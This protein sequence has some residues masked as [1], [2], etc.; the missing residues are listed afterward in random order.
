MVLHECTA[1]V[2][3]L[4]HLSGG[5]LA[6]AIGAKVYLWDLATGVPHNMPFR[7]NVVRWV[8]LGDVRH[9]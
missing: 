9:G 2:L 4:A 3:A 1:R 7:W 6:G 8:L 5:C